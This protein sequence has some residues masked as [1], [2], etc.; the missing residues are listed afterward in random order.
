VVPHQPRSR[1]AK[2][3]DKLRGAWADQLA[4]GVIAICPIVVLCDDHDCQTVAAVTGQ[5]VKLVSDV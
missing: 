2:R 1:A 3:Q 4:A 5:P